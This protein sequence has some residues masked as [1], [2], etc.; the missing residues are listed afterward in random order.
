MTIQ[1]SAINIDKHVFHIIRISSY[2]YYY[3]Y[4]YYY[5]LYYYY[6]YYLLY[7]YYYYYYIII[8]IL[9]YIRLYY[10]ILKKVKV[11]PLQAKKAHVGCG[12][13]GPHI[14]S[15]GT[16]MRQD[17]QSCTRPPSPPGK[18]PGTHFYRRLSGPQDQSGHEGV[19]K[20][21][22]RSDTRD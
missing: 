1:L 12:C 5:L 14:H 16:R 17:G 10:I 19:K 22:H 9:C 8:D 13:K 2:Y 3:Y 21:L 20:N 4:Y 18:F 6:Y 7:Y 11:S 15:H